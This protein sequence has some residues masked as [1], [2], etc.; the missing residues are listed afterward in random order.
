M[1]DRVIDLGDGLLRVRI[2]PKLQRRCD[3]VGAKRGKTRRIRRVFNIPGDARNDEKLGPPGNKV[4]IL[5][6]AVNTRSG[7]RAESNVIGAEFRQ[8]HRVVAAHAASNPDIGALAEASAG[9]AVDF[10]I[11]RQMH[12]VRAQN[13]GKRDVLVDEASKSAAL[14]EIDQSGEMT[15]VRQLAVTA[16][17]NAS[18]LGVPNR[19]LQLRFELCRGLPRKLKIEPWTMLHFS[20]DHGASARAARVD[21]SL[22]ARV[23]NHTVRG[24][25][26]SPS[27]AEPIGRFAVVED[28]PRRHHIDIKS[29]LQ[30]LD[31]RLAN[32]TAPERGGASAM[33]QADALEQATERLD[34]AVDQL[35][36]FLR[37][38]LVP[39]DE[40]VS[41]AALQEKIR[42]LTEERDRLQRDLDA[43][44]TRARRLK[45]ANEEVSG[46]LEAVMG[47]LK[48]LMPAVP[49]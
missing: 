37:D 36:R 20:H 3:K 1:A 2:A 26:N 42:F 39:S 43:E 25:V 30:Q 16:K 10:R 31:K 49:G 21:L 47:R 19:L 29:L 12:A 45:A 46:R 32:K 34:S 28:R 18:R 14:N 48:D 23:S 41:V 24:A 9:P 8:G 4:C 6:D 22:I 7:G 13:F 33:S 17:Q 15:F 35:E 40:G 5:I 44:K 11:G 27:G 38:A